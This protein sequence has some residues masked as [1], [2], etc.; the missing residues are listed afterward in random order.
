MNFLLDTNICIYFLKGRFRLIEKIEK[1]GFETL[2]ISE[3][4]L[5]ELKFGAEKSANPQRNRA[6]VNELAE[7]FKQLPI[8]GALDIYAREK[9]R[10]RK[11]GNIVDDFDLLIGATAIVNEM[12]MVT[13]NEKHFDRMQ[14]IKI[15]NRIK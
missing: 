15:E 14:N 9:A 5:A 4:T 13:N 8:Y 11:E 12:V 10:L 6:V 3:I 2:F 7:K 1:I